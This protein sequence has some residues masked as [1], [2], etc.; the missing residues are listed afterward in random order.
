M[1]SSNGQVQSNLEHAEP[2]VRDAAARGAELV[3]L[4]EFLATGFELNQSLWRAAEPG[5]GPTE[6]R[7][8]KQARKHSV[9][10]GTSFLE[11][12]GDQFR[13]TFVLVDSAGKEHLR[14][15]KRRPAATEAFLYQGLESRRV[16]DTP[17]GESAWSSAMRVS[18][19]RRCGFCIRNGRTWF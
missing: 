5:N 15:C 7:L 17:G 10:I 2:F 14:V 4:P 3:L 12:A 8:R 1:V 19:P 11:A 18:S 9:W 13:N 6:R 16:A